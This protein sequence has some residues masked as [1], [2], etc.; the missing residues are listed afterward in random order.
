MP[1]LHGTIGFS[2]VHFIARPK[3]T[4]LLKV[5]KRVSDT[6]VPMPPLQLLA[7]AQQLNLE[8]EKKY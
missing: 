4:L 5:E 7:T 3:H 8:R 2:F 6:S 1:L